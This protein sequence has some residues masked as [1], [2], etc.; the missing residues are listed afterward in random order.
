MPGLNPSQQRAFKAMWDGL[1]Q[2]HECKGQLK[3]ET[4]LD[5]LNSIDVSYAS[6]G[7][8]QAEVF[9]KILAQNDDNSRHGVL[10]P[11]SAYALF[12][13]LVISDDS[14]NARTAF[15][16]FDVVAR[17]TKNVSWIYYQRYPERRITRAGRA[18]DP[19]GLRRRLLIVTR[20]GSR[21]LVDY[22]VEGLDARFSAL[23]RLFFSGAA[24]AASTYAI[25]PVVPARFTP[26]AA[27]SELLV[28]F[29][30]IK[31][32]GFVPTLRRGTTGVGYTF[33]TMV[34]IEE[35]NSPD[36]DYKGIEI[37]CILDNENG[38]QK[39]NLNLFQCGPKWELPAPNA[40]R[41]ETI[42]A[43]NGEGRL[44]CYSAVTTVP[45][46][47]GLWLS[48]DPEESLLRIQKSGPAGHIPVGTWPLERLAK[49]LAQKHTRA[50]FVST[51]R[52]RG[53]DGID[54]Y[55]YDELLYCEEP[56]I[57]RF[58]DLMHNRRVIFEFA[59]SQKESGGIRNH[60]YPWR[61]VD[62]RDLDLLF[63]RQIKLRLS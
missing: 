30:E 61:L 51:K 42:G 54:S 57:E 17:E 15:E 16:V 28:K 62:E 27:L 56:S 63:A 9:V 53:D 4:P 34:G 1:T 12:P 29:D 24:L 37:K 45:N 43:I 14:R 22:S 31:S 36:A 58:I 44:A 5:Y 39:G 6:D 35:N 46:N 40:K 13:D 11:R 38:A 59:M 60:G 32:Q 49:R 18:L 55:Y 19:Q 47:R 8:R 50:V 23:T 41:L 25:L 52:R 2:Q 21:Y 33:E 26:D 7:P 3:L 20:L 48:R 10:I